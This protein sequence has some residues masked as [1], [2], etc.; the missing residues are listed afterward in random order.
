MIEYLDGF[1]DNVVAVACK[2]HVTRDDYETSL[3]PRVEQALAQ[4][5]KVR[6]YYQVGA[7]FE[8]IDPTAVWADFKVGM[9]HLMRWER[10]AVV[11]DV[12]WISHTMKV[13]SFLIPGDVKIFSLA[14]APQ[15]RDWI[16]AA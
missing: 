13:F 2:G 10:V 15:A 3:I 1:P 9:E 7:D 5:E 14:E 12:D 4:H 11:T 8:G 16:M 6:L